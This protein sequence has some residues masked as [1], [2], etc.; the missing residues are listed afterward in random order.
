MKYIVLFQNY[1]NQNVSGPFNSFKDAYLWSV[2]RLHHSNDKIKIEIRPCS[3]SWMDNHDDKYQKKRV[4]S[5]YLYYDFGN[6]EVYCKAWEN[7]QEI[8]INVDSVMTAE[9]LAK[10]NP[11]TQMNT[12]KEPPVKVDFK[13][14]LYHIGNG[15]VRMQITRASGKGEI[16]ELIITNSP[17]FLKQCKELAKFCPEP[18]KI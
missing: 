11:K 15:E 16:Q 17:E 2:P 1:P 5:F 14:F 4:K 18:R 9:Y 6:K 3:Q 12:D 10:S 13:D 7:N 8:L